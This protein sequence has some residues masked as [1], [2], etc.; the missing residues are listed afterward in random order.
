MDGT[1]TPK[2]R[3]M[4]VWDQHGGV[5]FLDILIDT[6]QQLDESA[7]QAFLQKLLKNIHKAPEVDNLT[8]WQEILLRQKALSERL[9]RNV[10]LKT[11]AVEYFVTT[12]LLR[13]AVLLKHRELKDRLNTADTDPLTGL[14]NRR[15]LDVFLGKEL[16]RSLRHSYPLSLVLLNLMNF[17]EAREAHGDA[18]GDAL[19]V[20]LACACAESV[21]GYDYACRISEDEFALLL[22]QSDAQG[23]HVVAK[24]VGEKFE[25][26][27]SRLAPNVTLRLRYGVASSPD[28]GETSIS[29]FDVADR[30][31]YGEGPAPDE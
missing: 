4:D 2:D 14:Y 11:A 8:H 3:G 29:L 12:S 13:N 16:S 23:A 17:K 5:H 10:N 6:L 18:A 7:Q 22:P 20:S 19:L 24:R 26:D 30:R 25:P 31:L 27:L 9:G 28:D 15:V 21:R 1:N